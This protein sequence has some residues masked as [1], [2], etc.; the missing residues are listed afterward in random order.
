MRCDRSPCTLT[1][2]PTPQASCSMRGSR[3]Q[4]VFRGLVVV[5]V[6]T[7]ASRTPQMAVALAGAPSP[8][9]VRRW[10]QLLGVERQTDALGVRGQ[11]DGG[12]GAGDAVERADL[13]DERLERRR[14]R[15]LHLE[16]QRVLAGDVV[17]LENAVEG[18]R[19]A[20]GPPDLG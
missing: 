2:K 7:P 20:L 9:A 14:A 8:L 3:S 19:A 15:R 6:M 13:G 5:M 17:A 4:L 11:H 1:T 10:R 16:E 12:L 18:D